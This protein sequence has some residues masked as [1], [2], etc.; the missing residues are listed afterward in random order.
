MIVTRKS[1]FEGIRVTQFCS[2]STDMVPHCF[3]HSQ[4]VSRNHTATHI[5]S[6]LHEPGQQHQRIKGQTWQQQQHHPR[7][8]RVQRA[9]SAAPRQVQRAL[10]T[11]AD[12]LAAS[13]VAAAEPEFAQVPCIAP[14]TKQQL[15]DVAATFVKLWFAG[16]AKGPQAVEQ[17][18]AAILSSDVLIKADRVKHFRDTQG[19]HEVLGELERAHLEYHRSEHRPMLYAASAE[20]QRA[21]ALVEGTYQDVGALPGHPA[22]FRISKVHHIL[23]MEVQD[24]QIAVLWLYRQL[25]EEDKDELLHEPLACYPAPFPRESL[26]LVDAAQHASQASRMMEIAQALWQGL[27]SDSNPPSHSPSS[28]SAGAATSSSSGSQ[29]GVS[30]MARSRRGNGGGGAEVA[31]LLAPDFKMWDAYGLWPAMRAQGRRYLSK[32]AAVRYMQSLSYSYTIQLTVLDVAVAEGSLACF[33]HWQARLK[34]RWAGQGESPGPSLESVEAVDTAAA[35]AA[36][37]G[38]ADNSTKS[39]SSIPSLSSSSSP[40]SSAGQQGDSSTQ[41]QHSPLQAEL[42]P[43]QP[44]AG[45]LVDGMAVNLFSEDLQLKVIWVFRGPVAEQE[46]QLFLEYDKQ[47]AAAEAAQAAS[48]QETVRAARRAQREQQL[49]ELLAWMNNYQQ[50]W[51]FYVSH[52]QKQIARQQRLAKQQLIR[53]LQESQS[54][55]DSMEEEEL[56]QQQEQI[57]QQLQQQFQQAQQR[58]QDLQ[59]QAQQQLQNLQQPAKK[60]NDKDS[61]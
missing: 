19:L 17:E 59:Q 28:A 29:G 18:L 50:Q 61:S 8:G 45:L 20:T 22:T 4:F 1:L 3:V 54:L 14:F 7:Q 49:S 13:I 36:S 10:T 52:V 39:S 48:D 56:Q 27:A 15:L 11:S 6:F 58:L 47:A 37:T 24:G 44:D 34:P 26:T 55:D 43:A 35:A 51:G 40:Q 46:M 42:Q 31:Q 23:S 25:T 21:Y 33:S 30:R 38:T 9:S 60:E 53:Q 12:P 5:A 41:Q 2:D 16:I 57:T 32:D